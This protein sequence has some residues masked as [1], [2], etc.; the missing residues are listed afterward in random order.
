[1]VWY[2]QPQED[3]WVF[4]IHLKPRIRPNWI[5]HIHYVISGGF[6]MDIF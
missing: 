1:M 6:E 2:W 4:Y 3:K 5:F